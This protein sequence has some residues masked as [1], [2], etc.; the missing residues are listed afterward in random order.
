M[1]PRVAFA[2]NAHFGTA[3]VRNRLRR[4]LMAALAELHEQL[5]PG[6]YL[7]GPRMPSPTPAAVSPAAAAGPPGISYRTI[8]ADLET[9]LAKATQAT[10]ATQ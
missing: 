1:R 8:L 9:M 2:I 4:R 5:A 6:R 10:K 7:I 3:T